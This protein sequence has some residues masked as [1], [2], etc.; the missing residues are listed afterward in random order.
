MYVEIGGQI[1]PVEEEK[2]ILW[3]CCRSDIFLFSSPTVQL[4]IR[5]L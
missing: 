2:G 4:D 1:G 5:P 3:Q